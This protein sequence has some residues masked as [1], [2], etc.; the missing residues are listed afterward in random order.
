MWVCATKQAIFCI[1][2]DRV[3]SQ[4]GFK[5]KDQCHHPGTANNWLVLFTNSPP[6]G[7]VTCLSV[8]V[9]LVAGVYRHVACTW[10]SV[11]VYRDLWWLQPNYRQDPYVREVSVYTP[12]PGPSPC[13]QSIS[14]QILSFIST[15]TT[16]S[17]PKCGGFPWKLTYSML[18]RYSI[19]QLWI[20]SDI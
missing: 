16:S 4:N 10:L 5:K 3:F 20:N 18:L 11:S 14:R 19:L 17:L 8:C 7:A 13:P 9:L 12:S 2:G 6:G 1:F 15:C